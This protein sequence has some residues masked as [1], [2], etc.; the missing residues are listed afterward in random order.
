MFVIPSYYY[1]RR[2]VI[3]AIRTREPPFAP[4]TG[5]VTSKRKSTKTLVMAFNLPDPPPEVYKK[6]C[7]VQ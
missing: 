6:W 1:S 2:I 5:I 7:Q 3:I 4:N